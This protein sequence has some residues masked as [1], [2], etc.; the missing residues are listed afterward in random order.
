MR[1]FSLSLRSS[2]FDRIVRQIG[3]ASELTFSPRAVSL[4]QLGEPGCHEIK[5]FISA[6]ERAHRI[7]G[8]RRETGTYR[9]Y[10]GPR[11]WPTGDALYFR[12]SPGLH[13]KYPR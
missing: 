5:A 4:C 1:S 8:A 11:M 2:F 9:A 7:S 3:R 10:F 13:K 12:A 6:C